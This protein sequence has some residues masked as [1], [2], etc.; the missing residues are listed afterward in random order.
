VALHQRA[1]G[2]ERQRAPVEQ[3]LDLAQA[4]VSERLVADGEHLVDEQ[5][6]GSVWMA[7]AKPSRITCRV[8]LDRP[9]RKSAD[10]RT[11]RCGRSGRLPAR[12]AEHGAVDVNVLAARD[13][14]VEAGAEPMRAATRPSTTTRPVSGRRMPTISE[15]GRLPEPLLP[16][17]RTLAL[18][19]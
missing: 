5:H 3:L 6:V 7:T 12:E 19:P 4:A 17:S 11:R 8:G 1:S 14:G 16:M 2:D 10:R 18:P 9:S 15:Q 13:L